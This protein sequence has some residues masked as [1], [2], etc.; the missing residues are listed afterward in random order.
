MLSLSL[1]VFL[2]WVNV[3]FPN[4]RNDS[5]LISFTIVFPLRGRQVCPGCSEFN[6]ALEPFYFFEENQPSSLWCFFGWMRWNW[7]FFPTIYVMLTEHNLLAI[8][9]DCVR[10]YP[11]AV[12]T[13]SVMRLYAHRYSGALNGACW[14]SKH[15]SQRLSDVCCTFHLTST[16]NQL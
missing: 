6:W 7:I 9:E 12:L 2:T 3:P 13:C 11:G 16:P 15:L 4:F 10:Y 14:C 8:S 5:A 1:Q